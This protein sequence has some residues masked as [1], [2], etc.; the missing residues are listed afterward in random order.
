MATKKEVKDNDYYVKA[1]K[2]AE[3]ALADIK[4]EYQQF[5]NENQVLSKQATPQEIQ[6][7]KLKDRA[8]KSKEQLAKEAEASVNLVANSNKSK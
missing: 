2:T 7:F 6:A 4:T 1:I 5:L 8:S 3:N